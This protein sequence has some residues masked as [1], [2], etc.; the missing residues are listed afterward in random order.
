MGTAEMSKP[1]SFASSRRPESQTTASLTRFL[2]ASAELEKSAR[3]L[4]QIAVEIRIDDDDEAGRGPGRAQRRLDRGLDVARHDRSARTKRKRVCGRV[5][6][7]FQ[8]RR[9]LALVGRAPGAGS[10][11]L[12]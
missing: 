4:G 9:C 11:R 8:H 6:H 10:L 5:Q 7:A 2:W 3:Q 1:L 12:A